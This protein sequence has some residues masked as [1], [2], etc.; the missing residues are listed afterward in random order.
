MRVLLVDDSMETLDVL[1]AQLK[2][3]PVVDAVFQAR[4]ITDA[5]TCLL[6]HHSDVNIVFI[7]IHLRQGNGLELCAA[8]ATALPDLYR[9]M[10]SID[11]DP[12]TKN[13][14]Y[15]VGA[16][17]FIEKPV[18]MYELRRILENYQQVRFY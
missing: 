13:D 6:S 11:A 9:V 15:Q 12:I 14:A 3:I 1:K 5:W 17:D 8:L 2:F 16:N 10:C 4:T 18:A 7:D